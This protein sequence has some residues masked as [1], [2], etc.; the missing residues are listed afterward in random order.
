MRNFM[1]FS[2]YVVSI[3][4]TKILI[5][6]QKVFEFI[7]MIIFV[8]EF[9]TISMEPPSPVTSSQLKVVGSDDPSPRLSTTFN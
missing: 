7:K 6:A 5:S 8:D 2:V 1:I 9:V 4:A 3:A